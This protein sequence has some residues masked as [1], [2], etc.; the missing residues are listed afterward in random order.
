MARVG[1]GAK[2]PPIERITESRPLFFTKAVNIS[3]GFTHIVEVGPLLRRHG[4]GRDLI[5]RHGSLQRPSNLHKLFSFLFIVFTW[6]VVVP[7]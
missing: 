3:W 6:L 7:R 4:R 2:I 1:I 5:L